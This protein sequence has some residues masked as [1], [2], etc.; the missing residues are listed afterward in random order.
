MNPKIICTSSLIKNLLVIQPNCYSDHRGKNFEGFN[1]IVYN[2]MVKYIDEFKDNKLTFSVDS[3]SCSVKNVLRGIHGDD[4]NW[5]LID[6]LLGEVYFVVIDAKKDSPTYKH[7]EKFIL[8]DTN[9]WQ[10]ILPP[11]CVDGHLVLSDKC[12]FHYKLSKGFV[13]QENQISFKW[14]DP[15]LNINWPVNTPIL[16]DRDK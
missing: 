16:G 5:K 2:E 10:V 1:D 14:N 15:D 4:T 8:N 12:I 11:G 6:V 7:I 9:K 3:Y 13:K